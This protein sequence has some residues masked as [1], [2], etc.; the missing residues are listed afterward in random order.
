MDEK[1]YVTFS[2]VDAMLANRKPVYLRNLTSKPSSILVLDY[3]SPE[4]MKA[5]HVP[6]SS[7][8]FNVVDYVEAEYIRGSSAF[9]KLFHSGVLEVVAEERAVRELADP[10]ARRAFQLAHDEAN[11]TSQYRH[12]ELEKARRAGADAREEAQAQQGHAMHS[13]IATMDPKMVRAMNVGS[14]G[15][16]DPKVSTQVSPRLTA[17]HAR[18]KNNQ[19]D[20]QGIKNELSLMMSDLDLSDLQGIAAGGFWPAEVQLWA[21]ERVAFKTSLDKP[22]PKGAT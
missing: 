18:V 21:R 6:R 8:P 4:G 20:A 13:L 3:P 17:L 1:R 12:G 19:V 2:E 16:K 11:K 22:A 7:I 10:E 5:F 14:D 15:T 9:R